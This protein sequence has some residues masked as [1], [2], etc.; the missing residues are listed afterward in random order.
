MI[1]L[2]KKPK[3]IKKE[4]NKGIFEIEGLFPGYGVTVGNTLRRVLLSSLE[5]AAI[6]QV[7]IKSAPH[8]FSTI[9]GVLEDVIMIL[10]NLKKINFRSFSEEPQTISLKVKGQKEVKA[11][12]FKLTS[13]LKLINSEQVIA[14]LT[15]ATAEFELECLVEKGIGYEPIE[16]REKEKAGVG[17][18]PLDA[19]YSPVKKVSMKVENM[20][21]GKRTDFDKIIL[22]VETNGVIT[23]EEA[24]QKASDILLKQVSMLTTAFT[25]NK[26]DETKVKIEDLD[27]A[28]RTK[29][30]LLANKIKTISGLT[31]K[32]EKNLQE[33]E[34][35]GKKAIE[36]IKEI[37]KN[38]DLELK[39]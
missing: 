27:M 13:E 34:G 15:K 22:E 8:E 23:P 32:T 28:E 14:N 16:K 18:L 25:E 4:D 6:T 30:A 2:P 38:M 24:F 19:L 17:V 12:D 31:K 10:L 5:G 26:K 33:I 39:Q 37:L 11:K 29:K 20:R 1:P 7:K 35:L 3:L 21:I 36:E 9:P